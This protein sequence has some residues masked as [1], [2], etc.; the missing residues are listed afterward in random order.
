M[1]TL[2]NEQ[3]ASMVRTPPNYSQV[4]QAPAPTDVQMD[5][6]QDGNGMGQ[7]PPLPKPQPPRAPMVSMVTVLCG[8]N[9]TPTREIR[10]TVGL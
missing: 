6:D 7:F 10:P 4:L 1:N 8:A 9:W 5:I 2:N 3:V